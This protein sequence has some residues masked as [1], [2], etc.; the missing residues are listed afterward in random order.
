MAIE[1][2]WENQQKQLSHKKKRLQRDKWM[3]Y[4]TFTG[5]LT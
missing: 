5:W 2:Q 4:E 1:A 3:K